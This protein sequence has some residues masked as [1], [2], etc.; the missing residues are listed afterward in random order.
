MIQ[1]NFKGTVK[2]IRARYLEFI[3][4][5]NIIFYE[6]VFTQLGQV[7]AKFQHAINNAFKK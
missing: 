7:I 6:T 3:I 4:E 5:W 1:S 2:R